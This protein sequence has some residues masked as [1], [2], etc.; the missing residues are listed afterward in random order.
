MLNARIL[1][2]SLACLLAVPS[3]G[4]AQL[5]F[6]SDFFE[7]HFYYDAIDQNTS[8]RQLN[9]GF[10]YE[11]RS[12]YFASSAAQFGHFG[13]QRNL[14]TGYRVALGSTESTLQYYS[15]GYNDGFYESVAE[16]VALNL[17][18][19]AW[20]GSL[21]VGENFQELEAGH[22]FDLS[23][24]GLDLSLRNRQDI[25]VEGP[26]TREFKLVGTRGPIKWTARLLDHDT[27]WEP[28]TLLEFNPTPRASIKLRYSD[29]WGTLQREGAG[30][31]QVGQ[32]EIGTRYN[33]VQHKDYADISRGVALSRS[34]SDLDLL[35][36][37]D[38]AN[39]DGTRIM[40]E[41]NLRNIADILEPATDAS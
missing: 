25:N 40:L 20:R 34:F 2:C 32:F 21:R 19:G 36:R 35:L 6:V 17:N 3:I 28:R 4:W 24:I 30:V 41:L 10:N 22:H 13:Y 39:I 26:P 14:A 18:R 5:P 31:V 9:T 7:R 33:S 38:D 29:Q 8:E 27:G 23:E 15:W 11:H 16:Q 1:A 37:I 12:G